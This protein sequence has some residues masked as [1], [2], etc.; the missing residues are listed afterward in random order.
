MYLSLDSQNE[1]EREWEYGTII[2]GE[3]RQNFAKVIKDT[4]PQIQ[5]AE[6]SP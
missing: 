1:G 3:S 4:K 2:G 6:R 5:E